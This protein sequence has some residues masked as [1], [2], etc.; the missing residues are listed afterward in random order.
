M[1]YYITIVENKLKTRKDINQELNQKFSLNELY[2]PWRWRENY[3]ELDEWCFKWNNKILRD[4]LILR[5]MGVR[6]HFTCYSEEGEYYKY[7]IDK[8]GVREYSGK[9][10]FPKKREKIFRSQDEIEDLY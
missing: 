10:I 1:G 3:L 6:G 8:K 4:F 9:V 7:P 2:F 5:D